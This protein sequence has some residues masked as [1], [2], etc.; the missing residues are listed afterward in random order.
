MQAQERFAE[1]DRLRDPEASHIT[2]DVKGNTSRDVSRIPRPAY[3]NLS[4]RGVQREVGRSREE[5]NMWVLQHDSHKSEKPAQLQSGCDKVGDEDVEQSHFLEGARDVNTKTESPMSASSLSRMST[6]DPPS[7]GTS[8]SS[9]ISSSPFTSPSCSSSSYQPRQPPLRLHTPIFSA[10]DP[11]SIDQDP[12]S[13]SSP[14]LSAAAL[15]ALLDA[16][17]EKTRT[18]LDTGREALRSTAGAKPEGPGLC[19][20]DDADD[21]RRVARYIKSGLKEAPPHLL[22]HLPSY[23][24][25]IEP[26][27]PLTTQL[28]WKTAVEVEREAREVERKHQQ[29]FAQSIETAVANGIVGAQNWYKIKSAGKA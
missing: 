13:P 12:T 4:K 16:S 15:D 10:P 25:A 26:T 23:H 9:S 5:R 6:D 2:A 7:L 27:T 28:D 20:F 1:A 24:T 3:T 18:L 22:P 8:E 17:I 14:T 19:A 21:D 11:N 29:A